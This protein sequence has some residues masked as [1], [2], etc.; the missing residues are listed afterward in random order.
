MASVPVNIKINEVAC[1]L[2]LGQDVVFTPIGKH[3]NVYNIVS[4]KLHALNQI[5]NQSNLFSFGFMSSIPSLRQCISFLYKPSM[6]FTGGMVR[7][8]IEP[9]LDYRNANIKYTYPLMLATS[10]FWVKDL[11]SGNTLANLF[12][13]NGCGFLTTHLFLLILNKLYPKDNEIYTWSDSRIS[14]QFSFYSYFNSLFP[15]KMIRPL[16]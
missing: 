16:G 3:T 14:P 15:W 12:I 7:V 2:K 4:S 1:G 13:I 8:L 6:L 5:Q 9:D 11:Y 10:M